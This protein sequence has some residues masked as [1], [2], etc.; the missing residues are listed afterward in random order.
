VKAAVA[1]VV[2][3]DAEVATIDDRAETSEAA[4]RLDDPAEPASPAATSR[5]GTA[6]A[7]TIVGAIVFDVPE[8]TTSAGVAVAATGRLVAVRWSEA[9]TAACPMDVADVAVDVGDV[10]DMPASTLVA[11]AEGPAASNAAEGADTDAAAS[12]EV[13]IM[14][15]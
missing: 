10:G 11:G 5:P 9:P 6:R 7:V 13:A 4:S 3:A 12:V 15:S 8:E 2:A 1:S 14:G